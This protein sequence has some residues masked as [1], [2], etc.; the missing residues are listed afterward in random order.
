MYWVL[1]FWPR[2]LLKKWLSFQETGDDFDRDSYSNAEFS[3]SEDFDDSD[4]KVFS[5]EN[6]SSVLWFLVRRD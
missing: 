5:G 3:E 1:Q 6:N 2:Q 4:G